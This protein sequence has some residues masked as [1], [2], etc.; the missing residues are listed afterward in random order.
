MFG[1]D[2]LPHFETAYRF[3]KAGGI[4]EVML[5]NGQKSYRMGRR[6]KF[7]S[8]RLFEAENG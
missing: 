3:V 4:G 5:A 2:Y 1:I 8:D 7:Y 6:E